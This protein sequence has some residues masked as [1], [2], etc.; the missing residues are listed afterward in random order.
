MPAICPITGKMSKVQ[1]NR[2]KSLRATKTRK[3]ANL[4]RINF[5]G[6]IIK[7]SARGLRTLDKPYRMSLK[8]QKAQAQA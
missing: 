6:Q 7:V 2:S 5:G 4:Q 8:K 1:N 3:K